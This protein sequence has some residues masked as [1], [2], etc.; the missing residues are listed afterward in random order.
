MGQRPGQVGALKRGFAAPLVESERAGFFFE[1][2]G[3]VQRP[4]PVFRDLADARGF[5]GEER[6]VGSED[7]VLGREGDELI[8][9]L[10]VA[11]FEVELVD[12]FADATRGPEFGDEGVG[13]IITFVDEVGREVERLLLFGD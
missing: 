2:F 13:V 3:F 4:E 8:H 12:D 9:K 1:G 11:A 6:C 5:V 10:F 7:A